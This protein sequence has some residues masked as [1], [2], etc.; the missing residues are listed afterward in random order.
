MK[1][2]TSLATLLSVS[3]ILS[4]LSFAILPAAADDQPMPISI[5]ETYRQRWIRIKTDLITILF[6]ANGKKP[7]FL[8]WYS[9]DTNNVYVVKYKGLIEYL[10]FDAPY[11]LHKYE[12][13]NSTI[14]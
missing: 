10:T 12:A 4:M 1:R 8:W 3:L 7:T 6:P 2:K 5:D 11:Y 14:Q 13:A 9:N